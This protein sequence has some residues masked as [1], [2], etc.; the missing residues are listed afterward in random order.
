LVL[1][2]RFPARFICG[3]A[4]I[5]LYR[6]TFRRLGLLGDQGQGEGQDTQDGDGQQPTGKAGQRFK[7]ACGCQPPRSFWIQAKQYT[8][9]R[10]PAGSA[11]RTSNPRTPATSKRGELPGLPHGSSCGVEADPG[12]VG[13]AHDA[14]GP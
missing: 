9:G 13:Q 6:D 14:L 10:S 1:L 3:G 4:A 11:A 2:A 7:V 5:R 8:P 12:L